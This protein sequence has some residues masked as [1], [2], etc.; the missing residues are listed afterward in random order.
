MSEFVS[1]ARNRTGRQRWIRVAIGVVV[2]VI[3]LLALTPTILAKSSLRDWIL[4]A[5]VADDAFRLS[6]REASFGYTTPLIVRGFRLQA[7][8]GSLQVDLESMESDRSWLSMW[9][10]SDDLGTFRFDAPIVNV[11]TGIAEG[12]EEESVVDESDRRKSLPTLIAEIRGAGVRI[13]DVDQAEP[14]VDLQGIDF[15]VHV[16]QHPI[17][18]VMRIDPTTILDEEV[19]TP[20]LCNHGV[21]LIAPMFAGVLDVQGKI[22]CR[23]DQ[24][25]VPTGDAVVRRQHSDIEGTVRLSDVEVGLNN[26]VTE[27]LMPLLNQFGV[28]LPRSL[29][30]SQSSEVRVHVTDGRVHHQ[31]LMFLLPVADSSFEINSTGSVGFDESLDLRLELALPPAV[32][33]RSRLAQML[34]R[35]PIAIRVEG[36]VDEPEIRL[37]SSDSWTQRL[38]RL[39][40][41]ARSGDASQGEAERDVT[42][43]VLQGMQRLLDDSDDSGGG[44]PNLIDQFRQRRQQDSG[45]RS[46]RL[47]RRDRR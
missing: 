12:D 5:A 38:Q 39:L 34:I 30:I 47:P 24:F 26:K 4:N 33:E 10:F 32:L 13:R 1:T 46:R 29:T 22:S 45:E 35:E 20:E 43:A 9:M 7:V 8:D 14:V 25:S 28:E 17:G 23:I 27:Q 2:C 36:T 18:T 40:D 44:L 15:T 41:T 19:L 31:G 42:G 21:Q 6:T 3:V 37:D 11:V 16:E